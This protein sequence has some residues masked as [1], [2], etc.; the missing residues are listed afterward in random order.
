[1][2]HASHI[3]LRRPR[4]GLRL[5]VLTAAMLSAQAYAQSTVGDIS[6]LAPEFTGGEVRIR[7]LDSGVVRDGRIGTDGRFRLGTLSS[8]RYEV[9]AT[10][11]SGEVRTGVVTV[12]AGQTTS[13]YLAAGGSAAATLDAVNVRAQLGATI[14]LGSVESR[15]TFSAEQLNA[16]PVARD[17]TSISLLTPGTVASSGYFGPAS[18]GGASAAENSYYVSGFNVTNLFDSLSFT[19]VPFQAIDQLDVQTGGYGAR[20][21]FSTGGVTSVNVKRGTN[22]WKGGFSWT[23]TPDAFRSRQPDTLRSDGTLLRSYDNNKQDSDVASA[24]IGGP[25]IQDKLFLFALGSLSTADS[26]AY[27][28]RSAEAPRKS[29]VSTPP[30]S[31]ATS[32]E[33]YSSNN[34]YWLLKLDWYLNDNNH[35]EYTGFGNNRRYHY[36]KYTANYEDDSPAAEASK[37]KYLGRLYKKQEGMTHILQWT[38]Y[39]NDDLTASF[40]YGSMRNKNGEYTISPDGQRGEYDGNIESPEGSCPYVYDYVLGKRVGCAV[41]S[42]LGIA[43]GSNQRSTTALDLTWQLDDHAIGFGVSDDVWKSTQGSSYSSG[44]RWL[45]YKDYARKINFRT[46]GDIKIEQRSWYLEDH[47]QVT[48]AFM[49]YG[50]LRN[51]SFNNKN[52]DGQSFVKQDNIWQP[53]AGFSWDVLGEGSS[54][55]FGSIG[56]YSLPIAANVALRSASGSYYTN[57]YYT[58]DGYDPVTGKPNITGSLDGGA[59]DNVVNGS[60]GHAPDPRSIASKGLKPYTQDEVILGYEQKLQSG[61]RWVDGWTLGAKLTWRRI[62]NVIDDTCDSRALYNAAR[63][64]GYDLSNWDNPWEVPSGLPGCWIYNPG[65]DLNVSLDVDGD[66]KVDDITVPGEELGPK[67]KRSYRSLTLTADRQ[68]ERWYAS[69]NYT[70][71]K[72]NGNYEGLVKSTNGQTD[73]GT[74]SDFDFKELMYGADGYLFNDRRHSFKLYG[75]YDLTDEWQLGA[76]LLIQSG[77]PITCLGG[78]MDTFGTEYGYTGVFHTCNADIE[79]VSKLG[80]NGRTPWVVSFDPSVRYRPAALPGLS[81]QFSVINLFNSVKP[82]QVYE[83]KFSVDNNGAIT[84]YY[85]FEKAKYYTT[86]RYARVQLQYDW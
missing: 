80:S 65:E 59:N 25:L 17:I 61:N 40:R 46:G 24:W 58:Y 6:G 16:L 51:D 15:T 56:R 29:G 49:L 14:D 53:R 27:G 20:Y 38:S 35:L 78:G 66:G 23:T 44:A 74:T 41:E 45:L 85:N 50:G 8:G 54:K 55:L 12:A 11:P 77:T 81:V 43:N 1:M 39:L 42:S 32:A 7:N 60:D 4:R 26:E 22:E 34:P 83:T 18:F 82:L 62:N 72:L 10:S 71:A 21:G 9:T 68:G 36:D 30:T 75:S 52:G 5:L 57:E 31:L 33:D 28:G 73:T 37:D 47:W 84:D 67:A 70:W 64:A 19:E 76:N 86:P 48:D 69:V 2:A 13:A 79:E 3:R 63:N